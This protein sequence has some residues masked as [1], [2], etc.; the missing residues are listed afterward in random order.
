MK[1]FLTPLENTIMSSFSEVLYSWFCVAGC[2]N[3]LFSVCTHVHV[4]MFLS[5]RLLQCV[6]ILA[7]FS[8][9]PVFKNRSCRVEAHLDSVTEQ[10][11]TRLWSLWR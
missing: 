2:L 1:C 11:L 3:F 6:K 9:W 5:S 8:C 4:C 10:L 7:F